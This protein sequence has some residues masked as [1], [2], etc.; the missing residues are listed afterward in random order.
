MDCL[1][2]RERDNLE[3]TLSSYYSNH[4]FDIEKQ[5]EQRQRAHLKERYD[6]RANMYDWDYNMHIKELAPYIHP[7]EYK[8]WRKCGLAFEWRLT[9]NKIPNRTFSSYIPGY[10]KKVK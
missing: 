4:H 8:T 10:N 2:F 9:E 6:H 1:K 5:L 7:K 3:D